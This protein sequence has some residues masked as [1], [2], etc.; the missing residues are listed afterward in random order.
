MQTIAEALDYALK[1][2]AAVQVNYDAA[3]LRHYDKLVPEIQKIF[4]NYG[5]SQNYPANC[6]G[7]KAVTEH[8]IATGKC[9]VDGCGI[10][11]PDRLSEYNPQTETFAR[12]PAVIKAGVHTSEPFGTS[13]P[14][15]GL[16]IAAIV[17]G[18]L[19][20]L[21]QPALEARAFNRCTGGN[22]TYWDAAF[23]QLR[24]EDCRRK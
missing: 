19:I 6:T 20:G 11:A 21:S 12:Q 9:Q 4:K 16:Y 22:A 15:L 24:I 23:S 3:S 8:S 2:N 5:Y 1:S 10:I 18:I 14:M 17:S 13:R 7:C